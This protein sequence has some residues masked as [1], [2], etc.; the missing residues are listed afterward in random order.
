MQPSAPNPSAPAPR[1]SPVPAGWFVAARAEA[2]RRRPIAATVCGVPLVLFRGAGGQPGALE[3]RCPHR[4]AP[5]SAGRVRAGELECAY[6]GWRFDRGGACLAVPALGRAPES[7]AARANAFP[8]LEQDGWVWVAPSGAPPPSPPRRLP[9]LGARGYTT[10]RSQLEVQ[11][12]LYRAVENVLDVPHTAF[13]HG[14]LFRRSGAGREVEV[15]IR[16]WA[17]R[18]EAEYLGE[19]RPAGLVGRVL[20]PRGGVVEHFDRFLLPCVAEV[21]YRLGG[22]S[23]LLATTAATPVDAERTRLFSVVTFRLPVPGWLAAPVLFP[24]ARVIL[25]QDARMLALQTEVVARF[26]GERFATTEVD[27]LG[28]QIA[29][30]LR[31]AGHGAS[32]APSP[33]DAP[34]AHEHRVRMRL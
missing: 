26:G 17:D 3:D 33:A 20:A 23:H 25:R 10:V 32:P 9:L 6:H 12:S 29:R 1:P 14:G 31:E 8:C 13:L 34:P 18:C 24:V 5:L 28:P 19:P 16:R 27:V 30:L 22:A 7:A 2:V 21:E 4:N 15:A 11:A